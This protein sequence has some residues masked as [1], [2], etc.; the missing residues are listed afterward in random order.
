MRAALGSSASTVLRGS[1]LAVPVNLTLPV[2]TGGS[3]V[4][5]ELTASS[6]SWTGSPTSYA[7]QWRRCDADGVD[8][9]AI[10]G[11]TTDTYLVDIADLGL[12]LRCHVIATNGA[13]AS[14]AAVS[15]ATGQVYSPAV[16]D[17]FFRPD[18]TSEILRPDGTSLYL[19][20][21]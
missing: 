13:G 16:V 3:E 21:A 12:T 9:E 6:G 15:D 18:G 17:Q 14:D 20:A 11:A 8:I 19:R 5:T 10:V 1:G 7:Y 2:I 4:G